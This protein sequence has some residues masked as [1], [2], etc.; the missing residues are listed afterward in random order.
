MKKTG[1]SY[2]AAR[3]QFLRSKETTMADAVPRRKQSNLQTPV[4]RLQLTLKTA[5]TLKEQEINDL[6]ELVRKSDR[7]FV[8]AGL[9][10]QQRIEIR[11][12]LA[13]QG[14]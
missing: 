8:R 11:E 6:G 12:V 2:T 7:D 14:L 13:S 9:N 4:D 1:E 5:Q 10:S 3:R